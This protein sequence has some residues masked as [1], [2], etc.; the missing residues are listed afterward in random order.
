MTRHNTD[1]DSISHEEVSRTAYIQDL[2]RCVHGRHSAD[3]CFDCPGGKSAGNQFLMNG[4][5]IGTTVR[6]EP[7]LAITRRDVPGDQSGTVPCSACSVPIVPGRHTTAQCAA[8][9]RTERPI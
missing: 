7:I 6:G 2:D 4:Q 8:N 5:R 3:S 1:W 9:Q